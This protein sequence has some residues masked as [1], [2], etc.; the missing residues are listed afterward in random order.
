MIDRAELERKRWYKQAAAVTPLTV[1]YPLQTCSHMTIDGAPIPVSYDGFAVSIVRGFMHVFFDTTPLRAVADEYAERQQADSTFVQGLY[2]RWQR[3]VR[4]E[5]TSLIEEEL[6]RIVT[7]EQRELLDTIDRFTAVYER[8]WHESIFHDA[9]DVWGEAMVREQLG[10]RE[11]EVLAAFDL[12]GRRL[13]PTVYQTERLELLTLAESIRKPTI[14][15]ALEPGQ[16]ADHPELEQLLGAH[17]NRYHWL[18]NDYVQT[19]QLG[20]ADVLPRLQALLRNPDRRAEEEA[21]RDSFVAPNLADQ[22]EAALAQLP[23]EARWLVPLLATVAHWRD[24]RK[25]INQLANGLV[26]TFGAAL[27][28]HLNMPLVDVHSCYYWELGDLVRRDQSL[29]ARIPQR[30]AG[31]TYSTIGGSVTEYYG[32]EH[33]QL[34]ATLESLIGNGELRGRVAFQGKVRGTA[35]LILSQDDFGRFRAG[36]ILVAP[37]T[38]PEYLPIMRL[39]AAVVTE[40]GGLTSHAA[41]VARE[42]SVPTIV[43][44]QGVISQLKDGDQIEVDAMNGIVRK[45]EA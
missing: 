42:L 24:A 20:P 45:L 31:F 30:Q 17:A 1:S 39:A 40:E 27:A 3:G 10:H 37:N 29:L 5:V 38:R 4:N 34:L 9:F 6:P 25:A 11:A 33:E 19:K 22:A 15:A 44:V 16:L 7:Y 35:R 32:A 28:H 2:E 23:A 8:V 18:Q 12:V 36:D 41:I 21:L 14:V 26:M 43:G 13:G